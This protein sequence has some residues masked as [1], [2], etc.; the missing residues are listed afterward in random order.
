M[1]G[2]GAVSE[3]GNERVLGKLVQQMNS[4]LPRKKRLL[5]ELLRTP[6][7]HY[8][9]RDGREYVLQKGE[10]KLLRAVLDARGLRAVELPIVLLTDTSLENSAW[11]VEGESECEAILAILGRD[12]A[13]RKDKLFL[14]PAHLSIVRRKLPTTTVPMFIP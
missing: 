14:Y 4:S 5:S 8:E 11:R 3:I 12:N 6:D 2:E 7:P 1:I 9:G 10:L 13:T